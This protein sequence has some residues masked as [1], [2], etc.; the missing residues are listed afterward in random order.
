MKNPDF[1]SWLRQ[2]NYG[3]SNF[4]KSY[5]EHKP[6]NTKKSL[7]AFY[8]PQF[9]PIKE[10]NLNWG[11][12]FTEWRNVA[13]ALPL[14]NGH[15]QPRHPADL[16]YYD[17]RLVDIL[18][19]QAE[20]ANNYG[21]NGFAFYYYWFDSKIILDT[22][23]EN[24]YKNRDIPI[25]YCVFW[26][27]EN[28]TRSWDGSSNNILIAQNHSSE[29]D[30]RFIANI[31]KYFSDH[32]YIHYQDKPLLMIYRPTLMPEPKKTVE[33]WKNW[34]LKNGIPEPYLLTSQAFQTPKVGGFVTPSEIGFDAAFE[35]P[36]HL[37]STFDS[38]KLKSEK[39]DHW[40]SENKN[41]KVFS[42]STAVE[43]WSKKNPY[44]FK[45]F[46]CAFPS[47]DNSSRRVNGG[48][49]IFQNLSPLLYQKWL[50]NNLKLADEG[51]FVFINAWNE[52]GEG[53]YLE[54]DTIFGHAFLEATYQAV[55][56]TTL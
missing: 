8:L 1:H 33:R 4:F 55:I 54:P 7:I 42:Y 26:A 51:D 3:Q 41:T 50:E 30:I 39:I 37:G 5:V 35:F 45:H 19:K 18:Y 22:P 23:I 2:V 29:D 43:A 49:N 38:D 9:H 40:F 16:G 15:V 12:G 6:V 53:A 14:Y 10:N 46:K 27:N 21:V 36:P 32:R 13:R 24:L 48:A 11:P 34:C 44:P 25:Q 20:L 52:W 17:L 47:W 56:S 31:S 28:W